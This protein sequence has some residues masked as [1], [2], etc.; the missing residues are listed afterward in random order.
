MWPMR[1]AGIDIDDVVVR[2]LAVLL[3]RGGFVDTAE[4]LERAVAADQPDVALTI[5]E[6]EAIIWVLDN[7]RTRALARLRGVLVQ[8]HVGRVRDGLV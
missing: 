7:T 2:E 1:L 8:E 3:R 5:L 4:T 6:R